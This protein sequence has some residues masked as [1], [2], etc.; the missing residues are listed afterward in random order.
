LNSLILKIQDKFKPRKDQK[1]AAVEHA[2]IV[3]LAVNGTLLKLLDGIKKMFRVSI[4]IG[5]AGAIHAEDL[6]TS[7]IEVL[8]ALLIWLAGAS[9]FL[10]L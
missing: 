4:K 9:Q 7:Q 3:V 1:I 8:K 5:L 2:R 6:L 10:L